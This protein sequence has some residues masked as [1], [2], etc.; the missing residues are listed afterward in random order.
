MP[1]RIALVAAPRQQRRAVCR[2]RDQ[3]DPSATFRRARDFCERTYDGLYVLTPSH[4]LVAAHQVIG[5]DLAPFAALGAE[6]R[7]RWVAAVAA[8]LRDLHERSAEPPI[9]YLYA[10]G[11]VAGPLQH[12]AAFARIERPLGG[13]GVGAQRRW[14]DERLRVWPRV[15]LTGA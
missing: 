11:R 15:R 14:Y 7:G 1:Q 2:A 8:R 6:E 9:F 10:G 4:G 5:P 3:Y 13:L 12:A